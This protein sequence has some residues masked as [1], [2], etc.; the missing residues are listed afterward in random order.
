[1]NYSKSHSLI[2]LL[3]CLLTLGCHNQN[4]EMQKESGKVSAEGAAIRT[5]TLTP[6][7][8]A[9][10]ERKFIRRAD[11]KFKTRDVKR[12]TAEI[13]NL[14]REHN[15]FVTHTHL[16]SSVINSNTIPVSADSLLEWQ[17]YEVKNTM[18]IRV[19]NKQLD[20]LL[21]EIGSIAEFTD[22]RIIKAED[23][24]LQLLENTL[25]NKRA[26]DAEKRYTKAIDEKSKKLN[27]NIQAEADVLALQNESDN[28]ALANL[29]Y[30][31]KVNFSTVSL[32]FYQPAAFSYEK[33]VN[34]ANL[35]PFKPSL[36]S[37]LSTAFVTGWTI[38]EEV[39]VFL[40]SIWALILLSIGGV[41][42]YKWLRPGALG[43][44]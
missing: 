13:E 6:E 27:E 4:Y 35:K 28:R 17:E 37:R 33:K 30:M 22:F 24:H 18:S 15:G 11:L 32:D 7:A 29:A 9:G 44:M 26:S 39:L 21:T 10:S 14:T 25:K 36:P 2:L 34:Y 16:T 8:F 40:V 31:D 19:P 38:L 42:L 43:K 1:M 12:T 41:W 23:V 20:S 5:D 3:I